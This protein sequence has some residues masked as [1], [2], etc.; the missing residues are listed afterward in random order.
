MILLLDNG[1]QTCNQLWIYASALIHSIK[2]GERI[3]VLTYDKEIVN[4]PNLLHSKHFSFP[5]FSKLMHKCFGIGTYVKIIRRLLRGKHHNFY[6]SLICI[7]RGKVIKPWDNL[8]DLNPNEYFSILKTVFTFSKDIED[9]VDSQFQDNTKGYDI[10]VGVHIRR[11]DYRFWQCGNY[12]FEMSYYRTICERIMQLYPNKRLKF[13]LSTNEIVNADDWKEIDYFVINQSSAMKD[14]YCLSKCNLIIGP[15]SS[16]SR[17]AAF[18]GEKK[19]CFIQDKNQYAFNFKQVV[20]YGY[21]ADGS[22][23]W[24]NEYSDDEPSVGI[25]NHPLFQINLN[26]K[27]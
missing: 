2:T 9:S 24:Y 26:D 4:F 7:F 23:I 3:C 1:G 19:L 10:I 16:F 27:N 12:F 17:W 14:L 8:Y 5:L 18:I 11:G 6:P 13:F 25:P 20:T 15:P 22:P 21:F